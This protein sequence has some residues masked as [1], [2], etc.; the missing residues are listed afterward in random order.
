MLVSLSGLT[1]LIVA[2]CFTFATS[3]DNSDLAGEIWHFF[4]S[5]SVLL[6]GKL[7]AETTDVLSNCVSNGL[8]VDYCVHVI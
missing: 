5:K 1:Y 7:V 6:R 8:H 2:V 4:Q 3:G